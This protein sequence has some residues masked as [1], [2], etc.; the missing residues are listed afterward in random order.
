[1]RPLP[2]LLP[3][4]VS[5]LSIDELRAHMAANGGVIPDQPD[6]PNRLRKVM[7]ATQIRVVDM[8]LQY[9]D[10][11]LP[12]SLLTKT[13]TMTISLFEK[14]PHEMRYFGNGTLPD[15]MRVV[16]DGMAICIGAYGGPSPT[17]HCWCHQRHGA[18]QRAQCPDQKACMGRA[19]P[20]CFG[21]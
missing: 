3:G 18:A 7:R 17:R 1:M 14:D 8:H 21:K 16:I 13:K 11:A 10:H 6:A 12:A 4:A 15:S 20:N 19:V 9:D 5:A 2:P